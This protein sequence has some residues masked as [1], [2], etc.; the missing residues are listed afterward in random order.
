MAERSLLVL[1]VLIH[2]R[3]SVLSEEALRKKS[4][5]RTTSDSQSNKTT[6]LCDNP[7]C[8]ALENARDVERKASSFE[9]FYYND[10]SHLIQI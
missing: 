7:Y 3:K 1:L 5:D 6:Y 9:V 10:T 8:K 4:D 2:N